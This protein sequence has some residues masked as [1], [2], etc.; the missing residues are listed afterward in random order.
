MVIR[1]SAFWR[2]LFNISTTSVIHSTHTTITVTT[3][4]PSPSF[5]P[6][7]N[8]HHHRLP[9][10]IPLTIKPTSHT[11]VP[12]LS[13]PQHHPPYHIFTTPSFHPPPQPNHPHLTENGRYFHSLM[14]EKRLH[15][16]VLIKKWKAVMQATEVS[17]EGELLGARVGGGLFRV[18]VGF[19][20]QYC[21]KRDFLELFSNLSNHHHQQNYSLLKPISKTRIP[22]HSAPKTPSQKPIPTHS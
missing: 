9:H 22:S 2:P 13:P 11:M 14:D 17:K 21:L 5:P 4:F 12:H 7:N 8:P 10:H 20:S 6:L 16:D 18:K 1:I 15:F 19:F 3:T